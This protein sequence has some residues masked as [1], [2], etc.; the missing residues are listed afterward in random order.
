MPRFDAPH[1][2]EAVIG[3]MKVTIAAEFLDRRTGCFPAVGESVA[4]DKI[5]E[6]INPQAGKRFV[7]SGGIAIQGSHSFIISNDTPLHQFECL[8]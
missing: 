8:R 7:I 1:N 4:P 3:T 5:R 2:V 6:D